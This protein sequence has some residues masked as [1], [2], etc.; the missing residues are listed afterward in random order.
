MIAAVWEIIA[1]EPPGERSEQRNT[2]EKSAPR[3]QN[4]KRSQ[5]GVPEK[6][7]GLFKPEK[8]HADKKAKE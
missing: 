4:F 7:P 8:Q 1:D 2:L 5:V 3:R 6:K